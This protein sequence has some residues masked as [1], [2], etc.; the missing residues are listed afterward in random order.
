M[1]GKTIA[2]FN[3]TTASIDIYHNILTDDVEDFLK[4]TYGRLTDLEWMVSDDGKMNININ[5]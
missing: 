3:Y 1:N 5:N 4:T 2:V